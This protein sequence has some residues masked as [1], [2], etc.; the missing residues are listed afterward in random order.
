MYG[1]GLVAWEYLSSLYY[2]FSIRVPFWFLL[3]DFWR[4][5]WIWFFFSSIT[6]C[7]NFSLL[8]SSKVD[9][10]MSDQ[11]NCVRIYRNYSDYRADM[12]ILQGPVEEVVQYFVRHYP[13]S[14]DGQNWYVDGWCRRPWDN[15]GQASGMLN[16]TQIIL[17]IASH[18][19]PL[20]LGK[21]GMQFIWRWQHHTVCFIC[22]PVLTAPWM[23]AKL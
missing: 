10:L 15:F 14:W 11:K 1:H 18:G 4:L 16:F 6:K 23:E 8:C 2:M 20:P 9:V 21:V 17:L 22:W 7:F 5:W 19:G 3:A 13:S 12:K